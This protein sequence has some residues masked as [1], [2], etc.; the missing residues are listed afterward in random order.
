MEL[1]AILPCKKATSCST[2]KQRVS[3]M[4]RNAYWR[5]RRRYHP[6]SRR[7]S[8][9]VALTQQWVLLIGG[10]NFLC[11]ILRISA[12]FSCSYCGA[13]Y[14]KPWERDDE[15]VIQFTI[16]EK[17]SQKDDI[18]ASKRSQ[19]VAGLA[20]WYQS[21]PLRMF[22]IAPTIYSLVALMAKSTAFGWLPRGWIGPWR[23]SSPH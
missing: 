9:K 22:L 23:K 14:F 18:N 6:K 4:R 3:R 2:I 8:F 5:P 13:R 10:N 7:H 17:S 15:D 1:T 20:P 11:F 16:Q 19:G 12:K 21:L